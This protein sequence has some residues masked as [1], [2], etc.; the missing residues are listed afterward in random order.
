MKKFNS[1][2]IFNKFYTHCKTSFFKFLS[3]KICQFSLKIVI[4]FIYLCFLYKFFNKLLLLLSS[5]LLLK[6]SVFYSMLLKLIFLCKLLLFNKLKASD[7]KLSNLKSILSA[8]ILFYS[9]CQI[10]K[11]QSSSKKYLI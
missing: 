1:L 10:L 9:L 7:L 5:S 6:L 11:I 8:L 4:I 2:Q 3:N